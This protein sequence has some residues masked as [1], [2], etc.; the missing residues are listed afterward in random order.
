[1]KER[2]IIFNNEMVRAILDGRKTQTRRVIKPQPTKWL[3]YQLTSR[4]WITFQ[5]ND[6]PD[7]L[8][9]WKCPY[10]VPGD[11]LYVRETWQICSREE[12]IPG[13]PTIPWAH[14]PEQLVVVYRA[15]SQEVNPDHP[16]W[17]RSRWRPSIHMPKWAARLWLEITDIRVE[18]VQDISEDDARAEG[19]INDPVVPWV[20]Q[21]ITW[22]SRLWN[23]INE[24]RS[25]G[26][27]VNPWVWVVTFR[28]VNA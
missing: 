2:P 13:E 20:D 24:K 12:V 25:Y 23:S 10:G 27:D 4:D 28:V 26:W 16:E 11:R 18:R 15:S 6:D 14:N 1:M 21:P 22:F 3:K 19:V 17:G 7:D 5:G 8:C 9:V